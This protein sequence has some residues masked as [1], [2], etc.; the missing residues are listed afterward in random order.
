MKLVGVPFLMLLMSQMGID[1][2]TR[3]GSVVFM[4]STHN[5]NTLGVPLF[6]FAIRM[7]SGNFMWAAFILSALQ[8]TQCVVTALQLL[9]SAAPD[10]KPKVI[11]NAILTNALSHTYSFVELDLL[12]LIPILSVCRHS[13]LTVTEQSATLLCKSSQTHS[14]CSVSSM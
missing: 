12:R 1:M 5:T 2:L 7:S 4:D 3:F 11:M 13:C 14:F 8:S 10:W 9:K 6:T